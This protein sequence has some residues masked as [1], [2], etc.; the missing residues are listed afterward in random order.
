[1]VD[2]SL[3][4]SLFY[5][6]KKATNN[7]VESLLKEIDLAINALKE[8][9]CVAYNQMKKMADLKRRELK[10]KVGEEVYLN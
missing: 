4:P 1:M 6:H 7:E 2:H 9:L 10:F 8:N 5:R 3:P